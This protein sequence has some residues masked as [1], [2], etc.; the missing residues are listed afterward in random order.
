MS[1]YPPFPYVPPFI[2][3]PVKSP[4]PDLNITKSDNSGQIFITPFI[5]GDTPPASFFNINGIYSQRFV[6]P[7]QKTFDNLHEYLKSID[8]TAPDPYNK[9]FENRAVINM[10]QSQKLIYEN[11][12]RLYQKVYQYNHDAYRYASERGITPYYYRF[13]SASELSDFKAAVSILQKLYNVNGPYLI[14]CLF[15]IPFP[16][17]IAAEHASINLLDTEFI[18]FASAA[19]IIVGAPSV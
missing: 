4:C 5:Y 12:I 14:Q 11:Q 2:P 18:T 7:V 15:W 19:P 6:R 8:R 1:T 17:S 16:G 13:K 3:K 10:S 9:P